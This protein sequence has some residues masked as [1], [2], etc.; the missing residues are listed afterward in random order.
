MASSEHLIH[1]DKHKAETSKTN[2]SLLPFKPISKIHKKKKPKRKTIP[3]VDVTKKDKNEETGD[4][5]DHDPK[6]PPPQPPSQHTQPN[7]GAKPIYLADLVRQQKRDLQGDSGENKN[8]ITVVVVGSSGCGKSTM[9]KTIF[10]EDVYSAHSKFLTTLFTNSQKSDALKKLDKNIIIC[11]AGVDEDYIRWCFQMNNEYD[12][13]YNF[14]TMLDDVIDFRHSLLVNQMFLIMRNT[15]MTSFCSLQYPNHIPPA[16][17]ISAYFTFCFSSNNQQGIEMCVRYYLAGYLPGGTIRQ[18]MDA[19]REWTEGGE[20]KGRGHRFFMLDNLNHTCFRIDEN[21]MCYKMDM[22]SFAN[23]I[24]KS[25]GGLGKEGEEEQN[26]EQ[27]G[28]DSS[29]LEG[30]EDVVIN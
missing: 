6:Q 22:L 12:K 20:G 25:R 14:V 15:N 4:T 7:D 29:S 26:E 5:S 9:I 21:Y 23:P 30:Y 10:L 19:Y 13:R 27:Y 16:I 28:D 2:Q 18:K 3:T 11:G 24:M 17:R 8:G 1:G